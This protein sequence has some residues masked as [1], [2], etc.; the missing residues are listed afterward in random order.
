[1]IIKH[2]LFLNRKNRPEFRRKPRLRTKQSHLNHARF[3]KLHERLRILLV[4][5][6]NANYGMTGGQHS[7]TTPE[8]AFTKTS[9]YGNIEPQFDICSLAASAEATYVA[10]STT[11]HTQQLTAFITRALLHKGFALVEAE[12]DCISLYGRLN[13]CGSPTDML[14]RWKE[15][16]VPV[17]KAR[18]MTEEQLKGKLITGEFVNRPD[19][20]EYTEQYRKIIEKAQGGNP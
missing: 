11:Y 16:C 8:G 6:N 13:K 20:P 14:L 2:K 12:C 5:F 9:V 15:I 17:E 7:P 18:A 4:N 19:R 3:Q 10:R 1:M